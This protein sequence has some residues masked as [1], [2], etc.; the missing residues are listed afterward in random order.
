[1]DRIH[2][3]YS[4]LFSKKVTNTSEVNKNFLSSLD[5]PELSDE[6]KVFCDIDFTKE[7]L[8]ETLRSMQGGKS[9]GN[10]G[11][12]KEFYI[13]FW[14][15]VGDSVYESFMEAKV[16]GTLSPS[17]RQALI[18][19]I[20]KKDRDKRFIENWRPISLLNVDTKIL[21]KTIATKLKTVLP[22][23]VRSDQTAYVPGRFIGESCRLISDVIETADKLN[24]EGWLVTMDIQ[25][26]FD[27][28]DHDFLFCVLE[29]AGF[30]EPFLNWIK[31]L[32]KNQMSC[33]TNAGTTTTYFDLLRGC[34][35]GDP[36]SAYLFILVIEV[37]F[38]MVRTNRLIEGLTILNFEHKLTAYADDS[39][40]FLKNEASVRE[41]LKTFELF[42]KYSG[43]LL[44]K[45]KC[46]LAGIGAKKDSFGE[47]VSEL[48][49][50]K[51]SGDSVKILGIHYT[52]DK[53]ILLEKNF[54]T[55]VKKITS[56]IA[57]WKWR[58]LSLAGKVTVFKTLGI[59]KAVYIAFL[60]TVPPQIL[61]KLEEIQNDFLWDGKRPKVAQ[62][63]AYSLLRGWRLKEC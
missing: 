13:H 28:V 60:T 54:T 39:T 43:L 16:K 61:A 47:S 25:K 45:S 11:L 52:Y 7:E 49:K 6:Q 18:K 27:S 4:T 21:S 37:F 57:M 58:C 40:F 24:I 55:V 9:P 19:L 17:Q 53:L 33:V 62:K 14:D 20:A 50:V 48:K 41:L 12:T 46:E 42:S 29:N 44:N 38:Q 63:N 8:Y 32:V 35:Q 3:F 5:L 22:T 23:L 2:R 1:M 30:G 15:L 31:I 59:S 26:A 51:L 10:D 56:G 34:R 36:I